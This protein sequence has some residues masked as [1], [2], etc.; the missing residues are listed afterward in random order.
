MSKLNNFH[1]RP[2][3][4]MQEDQNIIVLEHDKEVSLVSVTDDSIAEEY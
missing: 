3:L 2:V 4:K 1:Q